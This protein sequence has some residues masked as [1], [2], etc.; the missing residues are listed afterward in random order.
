ML[1]YISMLYPKD[2]GTDDT[3]TAQKQRNHILGKS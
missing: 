2:A 3:P 1:S